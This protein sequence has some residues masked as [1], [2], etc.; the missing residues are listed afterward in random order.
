[1]RAE[2]QP[3]VTIARTNF[4]GMYWTVAQQL[5]HMTSNGSRIRPGD[6]FRTGPIS[7]AEQGTP[8][9]VI[10]LTRRGAQ[11]LALPNGESRGFLENGDTVTIRGR[12]VK[13]SARVGFGEVVGT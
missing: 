4:R 8:G 9:S 5:A 13:G 2:T 3:A 7:R 1:M 12:A 11:P 6:L 10:E